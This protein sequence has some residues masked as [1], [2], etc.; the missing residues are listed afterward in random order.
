LPWRDADRLGHGERHER[1]ERHEGDE[2]DVR[3]ERHEAPCGE[4]TC[5]R[6]RRAMPRAYPW[7]SLKEIRH[8]NNTRCRCGREIARWIRVSGRGGKVLCKDCR[9]LNAAGK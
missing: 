1:H 8:H 2:R 9:K 3:H 4:P 7:H 5:P 6:R